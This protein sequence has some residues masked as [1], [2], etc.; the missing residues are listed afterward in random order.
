[1][2]D[3]RY[4]DLNGEEAERWIDTVHSPARRASL[5]MSPMCPV[6]ICTSPSCIHVVRGIAFVRSPSA[7]RY[8]DCSA[9]NGTLCRLMGYYAYPFYIRIYSF[10]Y[11]LMWHCVSMRVFAVDLS[12]DG[13]DMDMCNFACCA[14]MPCDCL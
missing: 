2:V 6:S 4:E 5:S 3:R 14:Y 9:S 7:C 1:M 10:M 11:H 13:I 8:A 12:K